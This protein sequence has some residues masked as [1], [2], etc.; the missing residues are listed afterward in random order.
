MVLLTRATCF[1]YTCSNVCPRRLLEARMYIIERDDEVMLQETVHASS[2]L[3]GVVNPT[4]LTPLEYVRSVLVIIIQELT[5][6][7]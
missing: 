3:Q 2:T 5:Y 4:P 7:Q 1:S 6:T